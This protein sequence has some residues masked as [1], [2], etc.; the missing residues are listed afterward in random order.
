MNERDHAIV[1]G[2]SRYGSLRP[3]LEGPERD[4]RAFADWLRDAEG[5]A[6]PPA[7]VKVILSSAATLCFM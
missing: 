1:V 5:G 7:N 4:A 2:I 3:E 6:V